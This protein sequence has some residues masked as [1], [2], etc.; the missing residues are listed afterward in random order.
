MPDRPDAELISLVIPVCNEKESLAQLLSEIAG[1]VKEVGLRAEVLFVDDGSTDG[2]WDVI[3]ELATHDPRVRGIRFRRN[4]GKAAALQAGFRE[5]RGGVVLTLDADLQDDP[6]EIP[7]FVAAVRGGFD[8]VSGWKKVRHDPWHK[9]LPSRVFN[10]AVSRVTGVKLHD[11]NCGYKAYRAEV[12]REVRLYGEL[13]RFVPVLAGSRGFKV[14]ELVIEHRKRQ[15]GRSKYGWRRFTRGFLDLI[16]VQFL[17]GY[18][19]RPQ[20]FLGR[21]GLLPIF[22]G[23]LGLFVLVF[24]GVARL[25]SP[26][27]GMGPLSQ[28]L[29]SILSV[30]SLLFGAQLV[31]TGLLAELI[32]DQRAVAAEPFS[33]AERTAGAGNR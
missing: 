4:F 12:L 17:T 27:F 30:A 29:V 18:G 5:A 2:S 11:H 21:L 31:I 10:W 22:L 26:E 32:V 13:H 28:I 14:G 25:V 15:F 1:G 6:K 24:N 9:V 19:D 33:V 3:R 8:V 7:R 20:H 16:S 23:V